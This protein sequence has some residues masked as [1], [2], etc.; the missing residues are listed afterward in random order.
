MSNCKNFPFHEEIF[1]AET[2]SRCSGLLSSQSCSLENPHSL[3]IKSVKFLVTDSQEK[4]CL[5]LS[6]PVNFYC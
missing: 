3:S 5:E 4:I 1:K 2:K 6:F